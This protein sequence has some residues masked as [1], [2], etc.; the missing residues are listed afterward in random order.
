MPSHHEVRL[1][2]SGLWLLVKG[3]A[4][5]FRLLDLSDRGV[6][7]SFWAYL[8]CLPAM[9]VA[10]NWLRLSYLHASPPGSHAGLPFILRLALIEAINWIIP[11]VLIAVLC[12][13]LGL[14][15]KF[16]AIV[17]T[18]NWLSIP[19]AYASAVLMLGVTL[20]PAA[21]HLFAILE[22]ALLFGSVVCSSRIL[23]QICGPE[24][25]TVTAMVMVLFVPD[26][27]LTV[28]LQDFL[29]VSFY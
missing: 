6:T 23:R 24:N 3:D 21:G 28:A 29:G 18:M 14:A 11:L 9:A 12:L 16:P 1:Y 10:W 15:R 25:L 22:M 27:L 7:R 19:F 5:G 13:M 8:W 20:L 26:W 4:Q 2:L 17:V